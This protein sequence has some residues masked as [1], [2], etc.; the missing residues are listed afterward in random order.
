MVPNPTK[1]PGAFLLHPA[2]PTLKMLGL[3]KKSAAF[4]VET[5][6]ESFR[7]VAIDSFNEPKL[8]NQHNIVL[9]CRAILYFLY[10]GNLGTTEAT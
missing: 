5:I 8:Y 6:V 2:S 7:L 1:Q 10:K 3:L 4:L 9:N